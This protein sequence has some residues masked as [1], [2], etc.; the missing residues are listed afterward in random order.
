VSTVPDRYAVVGNPIAH[1]KSPAI[2]THFAAQ[3]G[4]NLTYERILAPIDGFAATVRDFF[5]SGGKGLNVTVPFKFEAFRVCEPAPSAIDA[6]AVNTLDFRDGKII[7]H[8]TDG[9][10]LVADLECNLE[11]PLRAKRVLL[12]GAGGATYGVVHPV[13]SAG[14]KLLVVANRTLDKAINLVTRFRRLE[15]FSN[16]D[17]SAKSYPELAGAQFDL[18]I[19]ATSAGLQDEMPPLPAGIF[20]AGG[21]A[22]D[23]VYGKQTPFLRFAQKE[24][25]KAADGLGMLVEQ[26]A[27]AFFIWRGVRPDTR[28]VIAKLRSRG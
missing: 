24:G 20:A 28:P 21:L 19:N 3:T 27:A 10:G 14:P 9:I 23:M 12:M 4:Q 6:A 8:N 26:A 18:V 22:Y 13:L 16:C 7:G 11:F 15:K 1:S 25:A 2:H 17:V 5:A